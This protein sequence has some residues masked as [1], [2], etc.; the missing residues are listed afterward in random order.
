MVVPGTLAVPGAD[1]R[2]RPAGAAMADVLGGY[3]LD[4][5]SHEHGVLEATDPEELHDY[6]VA[7]RRARSVLWGG[8]RTFPAEE[9]ELLSALLSWLAGLTSVARDLDVVVED[10]P[11]LLDRLPE[12]ARRRGAGGL[13]RELSARQAQ[14][15]AAL[16]VALQG[17]R[18]PVLLRRWESLA[19]GAVV[20]GGPPGPDAD[21]PAGTV[22]ARVLTRSLK[23]ARR[24]GAVALASDDRNDWH[25]LRKDLKRFR[26]LLSGFGSLYP[27][28]AARPVERDLARLQDVLGKLQDRHVQAALVEQAGLAAGGRS[29]LVAGA[30]SDR[31]RRAEDTAHRKCHRAF[32]EF[33]RSDVR[34]ELA[35]LLS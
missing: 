20:G 24:S 18:Y 3:L 29:A 34:A 21:L 23:K 1:P 22:V 30:L 7:L 8:R 35:H 2:S 5:R 10:L 33:D 12:G 15:H 31:L 26:Y 6:R 4:L 32:R 9:R 11:R 25:R 28:G 17:A 13:Q 19:S 16:E 14:A 27:P